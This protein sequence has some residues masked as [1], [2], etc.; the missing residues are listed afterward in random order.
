MG[1]IHAAEVEV[2]G[3]EARMARLDDRLEKL[4][5]Q[6]RSAGADELALE[7]ARQDLDRAEAVLDTVSRGFD[8]AELEARGP[9]RGSARNT[10]PGRRSRPTSAVG[11]GRWPP[12]R[13]GML[14]GVLG[15]FALV[16][17]R[18][19]RV[20]DPEELPGR[21]RLRVLGVVPPLPGAAPRPAAPRPDLNA[22]S[23]GSSRVSII[24]GSRSAR[25]STREAGPARSIL[26]TSAC[27]GEGKTTLAAQLAGGASTPA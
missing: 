24:S 27:G 20:H 18:A 25:A 21:L 8:R 22:S 14:A 4:N 9:L 17:A 19:G 15:L 16:E 13:L 7:F 11:S 12:R 6:T 5:I 26:I 3:L 23:T 2:A 10:R 1:E